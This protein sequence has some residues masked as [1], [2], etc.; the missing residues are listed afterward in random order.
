MS[1]NIILIAGQSGAKSTFA[2]GLLHHV[3]KRNGYNIVDSIEGNKQDYNQAIIDK[4]FTQGEYP[5]QTTEGYIAHYE[6][7]GESFS[8]PGLGIDI[9]DFPGEQQELSLT[10]K[11]KLPLLQRAR[12]GKT[13]DRQT[14]KQNYEQNIHDDFR[15]GQTPNTRPE[16]E[17]TFLYHYYEA[18]KAIFLMNMYKITDL[19]D[20][21]LVYDQ[22]DIEH[23]NNE[24]S[25]V[26]VI[27]IAVDWL[28][29][30]SD[31]FD[32]GYLQ[33]FANAV[34]QPAR[35]DR[36]LMDHLDNHINR[37]DHPKAR[38]ILN[39]VK[40]EN[41]I[42]FFSVAIPDKGSPKQVTGYL[43]GDGNNGF[44]TKGFDEVIRWLQN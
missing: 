18:D 2:G 31:T 5:D 15:R 19:D 21:E 14:I 32:P 43:T 12:E 4:M 41:E 27:P 7:N 37:G 29:Y 42:D 30:D 1:G 20:K 3:E 23:A 22:K 35:R 9:V 6:L 40:G 17:T 44:E 16:W 28:G 25:D 24:F 13:D 8:R 11:G 36:E 34:L 33:R 39:Y 38:Q 26:A 10:P